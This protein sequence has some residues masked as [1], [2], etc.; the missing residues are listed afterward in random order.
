MLSSRSVLNLRSGETC[1]MFPRRREIKWAMMDIAEHV[2]WGTCWPTF[3]RYIDIGRFRGVPCRER[4]KSSDGNGRVADLFEN[5]GQGPGA[6]IGMTMTSLICRKWTKSKSLARGSADGRGPWRSRD[7]EHCSPWDDYF[8]IASQSSGVC[9]F[10]FSMHFCCECHCF[11]KPPIP[12]PCPCCEHSTARR[13]TRQPRDWSRH[14]R[15][16]R[17]TSRRRCMKTPTRDPEP[18]LTTQVTSGIVAC[19]G[20]AFDSATRA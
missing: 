6:D 8:L 14:R 12:S 16:E 3:D 20:A 2:R 7:P 9:C 5:V 18:R 17:T 10:C 11:P 13:S 19:V 1:D 4:F 15:R